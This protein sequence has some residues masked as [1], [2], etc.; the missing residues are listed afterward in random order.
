MPCLACLSNRQ[1]LHV[2]KAE[3]LVCLCGGEKDALAKHRAVVRDQHEGRSLACVPGGGNQWK[4]EGR[5]T[6][7][8]SSSKE[9]K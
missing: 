2:V 8:R 9:G 4:E 7:T 6:P 1:V 5:L 3:F